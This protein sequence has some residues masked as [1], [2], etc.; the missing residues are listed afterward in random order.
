MVTRFRHKSG[1]RWYVW[2]TFSMVLPFRFS[3]GWELRLFPLRWCY[4]HWWCSCS[5]MPRSRSSYYSQ[6]SRCLNCFHS[7]FWFSKRLSC[8]C[9]SCDQ[10]SWPRSSSRGSFCTEHGG[11]TGS[12]SIVLLYRSNQ[13]ST[14]P[15]KTWWWSSDDGTLNF[16]TFCFCQAL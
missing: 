11:S 12:W 9:Q 8:F 13:T 3:A 16:W 14:T 1:D 10:P 4:L 6:H 2:S 15:T 7:L 5:E